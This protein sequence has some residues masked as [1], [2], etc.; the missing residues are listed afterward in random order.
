MTSDDSDC[1]RS[2]K[3]L[4]ECI[5][6]LGEYFDGRRRVFD[7]PISLSGTEFQKLIWR[8]AAT[9]PYGQ[10]LS[11]RELAARAGRRGAARAAGSALNKNPVLLIVPC[12]RIVGADGS[13]KGFGAGGTDIKREL[14]RLEGIYPQESSRG[15]RAI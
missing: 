2:Q 6:Q 3:V 15:G 8:T 10:T 14:L 4:N 5:L 9:I 13:L 11:Y 12:H 7:I 1:A